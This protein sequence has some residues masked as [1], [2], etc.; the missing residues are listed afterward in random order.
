MSGT[1]PQESSRRQVILGAIAAAVLVAA[2]GLYFVRT[3]T[4]EG[5]PDTPD[6][7]QTYVCLDC[8]HGEEL[9]PARVD[10]ALKNGKLQSSDPSNP[11]AP[12]YLQCAK[13]GKFMVVPG[14]RCSKDN[15]PVPGV[16]KAGKPGC[17]PKCKTP[18]GT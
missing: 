6:T 18:I 1:Q 13:C 16:D 14:S 2:G 9:T 8:G 11:R 10:E 3:R 15:T 12:S 7:A 17:C 4:D 5:Q